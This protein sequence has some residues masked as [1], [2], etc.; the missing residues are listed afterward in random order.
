MESLIL[1]IVLIIVNGIFAMS[2]IAMLSVNKTLL[3]KYES[4]KNYKKLTRLIEQPSN[5]LST[6]QV[7]ITLAGFLGSAFAA[8]NFAPDL[9]NHLIG[10]GINL[11]YSL[12]NTISVIIITLI[13]SYF[14][15]LFG[16]LVPKRIAMKYSDSLALSL[17]GMLCFFGKLFYPIVALLTVS[18]NGILK[19]LHIEPEDEKEVVYEEDIRMMVNASRESGNIDAPQKEFIEN[20][21]EL[22]DTQV[23]EICTHRSEV[24]LLYLHDDIDKWHQ[25]I[26]DNR[27][28]FYPICDQDEDDVVG[29]L[30]TRDYF[31]LDGN[32]NQDT[33]INKAMDKPF[34]V[35]ENMKVDDCFHQM[36]NR[37][38]YFA[39][40]LDEYGGMTGIIT[41]H[42]IIETLLGEMNEIDDEIEPEKIQNIDENQWR[43]YGSADLEDVQDELKIDLPIEEYD[44]FSGYVLGCYGRIPDDGTEFEVD[45]DDLLI[46]VKEIKNHR[47]GETI[48]QKKE[49]KESE[50]DEQVEKRS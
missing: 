36:K 13:L 50:N 23:E 12:M 9:A 39:I 8:E 24:I 15:L 48:V 42:D 1:Q 33:I 25:V 46:N 10:W 2:E 29:V 11:D 26:H 28:T 41:L 30:D 4:H 3:Q 6:I 35:T 27:H 45:L 16:E 32:F 5:F 49:K 38:T 44:T 14:T 47:V 31:R 7:V 21:F 19:L 22:D 17:S 43:I 40:V 18:V 34:F 20:V 37:K